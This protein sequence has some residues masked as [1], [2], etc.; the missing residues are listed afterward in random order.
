MNPRERM[1]KILFNKKIKH[2]EEQ[3][4]KDRFVKDYDGKLNFY[5]SIKE[6][7]YNITGKNL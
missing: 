2:I 4:E 5:S 1:R 3:M 6:S 7:K